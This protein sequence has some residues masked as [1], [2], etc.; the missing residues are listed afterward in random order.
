MLNVLRPSKWLCFLYGVSCRRQIA[1]NRNVTF[2]ITSRPCNYP[3]ENIAFN[4]NCIPLVPITRLKHSSRNKGSQK[5]KYEDEDEEDEDDDSFNEDEDSDYDAETENSLKKAGVEVKKYKVSSLR[6]DA[7][8]KMVWNYKRK[9]VEDLFYSKKIY[10]DKK[11]L[12]KKGMA[13]FIGAEIDVIK[14][15]DDNANLLNVSRIEVLQIATGD[16]NDND[17]LLIKVRKTKSL[18]IENYR[19]GNI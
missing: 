15:V 5:R 8:L 14:N 16:E 10:V 7:L 13:A 17:H 18:L 1:I 9:G 3:K 12:L 2:F 19:E 6:V 4:K 11:L